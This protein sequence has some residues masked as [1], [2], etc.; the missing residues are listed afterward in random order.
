M[1]KKLLTETIQSRNKIIVLTDESTGLSD[2]STLIVFFRA[3]VDSK[4]APINLKK[5]AR[6]NEIGKS[7][8]FSC[9]LRNY[10]MLSKKWLHHLVAPR[11]IHWILQ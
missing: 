11:S 1:K 3:S 5:S 2:K 4:A 10:G 8:R 9:C 7:V 6:F